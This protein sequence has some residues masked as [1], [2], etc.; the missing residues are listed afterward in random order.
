LQLDVSREVDAP[1]HHDP[2]FTR[3]EWG[4]VGPPARE[5]EPYRRG[6]PELAH[7][8]ASLH[9]PTRHCMTVGSSPR[10]SMRTPCTRRFIPCTPRACYR[11]A[12]GSETRNR[13]CAAAGSAGTRIPATC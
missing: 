5:I 10:R 2:P 4:H 6:G 13:R 7:Q 1:I 3:G 9:G 11:N 12:T 8:L